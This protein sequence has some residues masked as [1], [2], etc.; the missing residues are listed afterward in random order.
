MNFVATEIE[1][2]R[3]N[4]FLIVAKET[5]FILPAEGELN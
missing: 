3:K 2:L 1:P 4:K 5:H